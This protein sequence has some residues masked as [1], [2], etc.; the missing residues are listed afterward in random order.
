MLDEIFPSDD[1]ET[2]NDEKTVTQKFIVQ[3]SRFIAKT[4]RCT[5]EAMASTA[6]TAAA[7]AKSA[8]AAAAAMKTAR[9]KHATAILKTLQRIGYPRSAYS[10]MIDSLSN[11]GLIAAE[12]LAQR[13]SYL[14]SWQSLIE[15]SN[16]TIPADEAKEIVFAAL[17]I[18]SQ[19]DDKIGE[20]N[21][22]GILEDIP[23]KLIESAFEKTDT[24]HHIRVLLALH[25]EQ[26]LMELI[27]MNCKG[28]GK[29]P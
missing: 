20:G 26:E 22:T 6:K 9:K 12:E 28:T 23:L 25:S 27:K 2:D 4:L 8:A 19:L 3:R 15:E 7:A 18:L 11:S 24:I 29:P 16:V 1:L 14:L 13:S 5:A 17:E 21:G 10:S